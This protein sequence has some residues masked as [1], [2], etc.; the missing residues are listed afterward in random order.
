MAII[1]NGDGG[2]GPDVFDR[3]LGNMHGLPDVSSTKPTTI[4]TVTPLI[5]TSEVFIVQTYRQKEVGDTIFLEAVGKAG[6][7]RLA[8]P[9]QVADAIARQRDALTGK[10]RSRAARANMEA[11][12]QRG[13]V[14]GF[15]K[16]KKR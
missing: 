6:A 16:G 12:M 1:Q 13:E 14:P 7:V 2:S 9:P 5:G 4:R 10:S 8:L 15:M 3:L 11:R